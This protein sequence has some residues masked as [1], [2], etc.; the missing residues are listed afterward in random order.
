[1]QFDNTISE[2]DLDPAALEFARQLREKGSK[3]DSDYRVDAFQESL[4]T[5]FLRLIGIK[6]D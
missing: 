3:P 5:R 6:R 1:M 4:G 2:T